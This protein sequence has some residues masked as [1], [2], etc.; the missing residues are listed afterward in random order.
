MSHFGKDATVDKILRG[1]RVHLVPT[2][3]PDSTAEL[4]SPEIKCDSEINTKN[5]KGIELDSSFTKRGRYYENVEITLNVVPMT[6]SSKPQFNNFI[7]QD[8]FCLHIVTVGH[9]F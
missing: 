1:V 8:K 3:N 9:Q 5:A 6:P 4:P 7:F 2:L